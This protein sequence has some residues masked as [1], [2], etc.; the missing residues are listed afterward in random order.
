[1]ILLRGKLVPENEAKVIVAPTT[2]GYSI[3]H[4]AMDKTFVYDK[5]L[6]EAPDVLHLVENVTHDFAFLWMTELCHTRDALSAVSVRKMIAI[7]KT[8][9]FIASIALAESDETALLVSGDVFVEGEG[10]AVTVLDPV[11]ATSLSNARVLKQYFPPIAPF[12][13]YC[14]A[15]L[16]AMGRLNSV[17]SIAGIEYQLDFLSA[18][19]GVL[20][21]E[22]AE[23]KRPE[24]WDTFEEAISD[25]LSID[26]I[27]IEKAISEVAFEKA[28]ARKTQIDYYTELTGN[29]RTED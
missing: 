10:A 15:K 29:Q 5:T 11:A 6:V 13:T 3:H 27:G 25:R 4:R 21:K 20:M 26:L 19:V 8:K 23:A 18:A 7:Q 1:M 14:H 17:D 12:I 16:K 24:W 9:D 22:L 28:K 2:Q